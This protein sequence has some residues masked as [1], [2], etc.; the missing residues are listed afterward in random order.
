FHPDVEIYPW[1]YSICKG[2]DCSGIMKLTISQTIKNPMKRFI[3]CQYSTCGSFKW[4]EGG[5]ILRGVLWLW[6][7]WSL[8]EGLPLKFTWLRDTMKV[9]E[10]ITPEKKLG[11]DVK[12]NVI[13]NLN[14]FCSEFKGKTK[15]G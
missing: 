2:P 12:I 3:A 6:G 8:V 4:L 13:M 9:E 10:K 5:L 15:L 14:D 1:I 7:V 11:V